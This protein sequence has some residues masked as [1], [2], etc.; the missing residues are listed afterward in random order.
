M[1]ESKKDDGR[2]Y[3]FQPSKNMSLPPRITAFFPNQGHRKKTLE[4]GLEG[5]YSVLGKNDDFP[6]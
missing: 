1:A 5:R 4:E 2:L 6:I 3:G